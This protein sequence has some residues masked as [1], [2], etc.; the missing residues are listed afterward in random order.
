MCKT[1]LRGIT[2][3]RAHERKRQSRRLKKVYRAYGGCLC[4]TCVREKWVTHYSEPQWFSVSNLWFYPI[5]LSGPFWLK[6]RRLWPRSSRPSKLPS[7][8]PKKRKT[9]YCGWQCFGLIHRRRSGLHLEIFFLYIFISFVTQFIQSLGVKIE[10]DHL[11]DLLISEWNWSWFFFSLFSTNEEGNRLTW[12]LG[13]IMIFL[14]HYNE[15]LKGCRSWQRMAV[16]WQLQ[17][18]W[19]K[20]RKSVKRGEKEKNTL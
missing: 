9:I 20:F 6:N 3:A 19:H 5:G 8:P 14:F 13:V 16:I 7:S 15:M 11:K 4:H 17:H 12:V 2:P 18:R 10:Q 1:T